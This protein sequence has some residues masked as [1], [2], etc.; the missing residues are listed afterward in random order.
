MLPT[1]KDVDQAALVAN[2]TVL[3]VLILIALSWGIFEES[4]KGSDRGLSY[5]SY[6]C[7]QFESGRWVGAPTIP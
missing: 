7:L 2:E 1:E 5:T 3:F 4:E 6:L